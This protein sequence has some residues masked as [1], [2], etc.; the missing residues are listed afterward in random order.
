MKKY[1]LVTGLLAAVTLSGTTYG[2]AEVKPAIAQKQSATELMRLA[3]VKKIAAPDAS[4]ELGIKDNVLIVSRVNSP[5][6]EGSHAGLNNEATAILNLVSK[7]VLNKPDYK[8]LVSIRVNYVARTG[9]PIAEKIVDS[10]EFR[11][12]PKGVFGP[13]QT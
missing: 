9:T 4:V 3:V 13:H 5:F 12:N 7:A 8:A 6:N 11:K 2:S 10:L 1:L